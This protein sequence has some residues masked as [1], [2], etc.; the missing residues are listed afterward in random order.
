MTPIEM[1]PIEMV[2]TQAIGRALVDAVCGGV[3]PNRAI[4]V[5]MSSLA[6]CVDAL[7]GAGTAEDLCQAYLSRCAH[8]RRARRRRYAG[9]SPAHHLVGA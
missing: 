9:N 7:L 8:L 2:L 5:A 6:G 1:T 4:G 3:E